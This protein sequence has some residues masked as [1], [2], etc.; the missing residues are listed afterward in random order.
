MMKRVT[1]MLLLLPVP[2]VA[3]AQMPSQA[4]EDDRAA[5][6]R[7]QPRTEAGTADATLDEADAVPQVR[8]VP[9]P[10]PLP[11]IPRRRGSMVGYIDD[12]VVASKVRVRFETGLHNTVPDRAE[13]FYAKC[14]CYQDLLKS[15]PAYDPGA[16]GPRPGAV[17]DLNFQQAYVQGEYAGGGRVSVFA[18]LP[19]RWIQP[20]AFV[21][22]TGGTFPNRA[23]VGDLR[24][25]AK[26]ALVAQ[27]GQAATIQLVAFL[28]T[29]KAENG[30]GTH[31]QSLQSS[32]L[33][34]N[35]VTDRVAI[36]SQFGV[37]HPWDGSAGN[38]TAQDKKF[39]GDVLIY[40][41]GPSV[42]VYRSS[43][44]QFA[45]VVELVG[46]RV[47]NGF[48]TGGP[49]ADAS[50]TNI[51]NLKIGGRVVWAGRNSFYAGWGHALTT[52]VWYKDIVR[53]EYRY[54]F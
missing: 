13:F 36:E 25:G 29:G 3:L 32:L 1:L 2:A 35:R 51:V 37:W 9:P 23:G 16:P 14:G 4:A 44:V 10:R 7:V 8:P 39:S 52:E 18:E 11:V 48:Q 17:S 40:G 45:P 12:A 28:P 31:H 43:R 50:G 33:L 46:W 53:F 19:T 41:V 34:F 21:P 6:A 49:A 47:L 38:P 42:E 26:I 30:L 5:S 24:A 20:Q 54:S 22:G 27:P 15:N